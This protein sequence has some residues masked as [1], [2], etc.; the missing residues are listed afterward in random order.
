MFNRLQ[1]GGK[2]T[3][4][5]AVAF[6]SLSGL[7]NEILGKVLKLTQIW[8]L[9]DQDKLGYLNQLSFGRAV[10]FIAAAQAGLPLIEDSLHLGS[11]Y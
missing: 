1:E 5:Q 3:A 9:S 10:K 4:Q 8:S 6:L 2:V 7:S 11:R